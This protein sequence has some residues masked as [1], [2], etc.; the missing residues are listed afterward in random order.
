MGQESVGDA[1][2]SSLGYYGGVFSPD[3]RRIAANGFT[4]ALHMW[5]LPDTVPAGGSCM[6]L[7]AVG[8]KTKLAMYQ[9]CI[10]SQD[11]MMQL[12]LSLAAVSEC[13]GERPSGRRRVLKPADSGGSQKYAA[14]LLVLARALQLAYSCLPM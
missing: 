10:D 8:C 4:G 14:P 12:R 5:Q 2:A 11:I 7:D 13:K 9:S 3:G 1:G 6:T